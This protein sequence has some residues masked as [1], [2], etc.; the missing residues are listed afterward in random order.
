LDEE[1]GEKPARHTRLYP[2]DTKE[3]ISTNSSPDISFDASINPYR[4]CEHG[5]IYCY[6][7]PTHEYLDFSAGL[8]FESRIMVKY[9]AAKKLREKMRS[10]KWNPKVIVMSGVT[11]CYQPVERKLEVT[12]KCLEVFAEFRNPVS[13]I[14]KNY[15]VTRDID[16]LSE[17]AR[18]KAA[19]VT[20]SITTLN[21]K[22]ARAMEPRTSQPGRRLQAIEKLSKAGI[23]VGVNVAPIIP[24]LTDHECANILKAA[25]DAGAT[26]AGYT[27]VRLPFGVK[28]LFKDWLEQHFP[29]RK[30]KVLNKIRDIRGGKLN[31]STYGQRFKGNGNYAQQIAD[32]FDIYTKRMGLNQERTPLSTAAFKPARGYQMDLF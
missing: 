10:P 5:C 26:R 21:G 7:R 30:D 16:Y 24:G 19:R 17:L 29:D 1:S 14:T 9:D 20:L 12:R 2:D 27:L 32:L 25:K 13:I 22:L 3:I 6:A 15:M 28:D 31:D 8:D 18:H 4:G 23:P 11:D